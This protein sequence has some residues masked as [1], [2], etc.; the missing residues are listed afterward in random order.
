MRVAL[1]EDEAGQAELVSSW[2]ER[3]GHICTTYDSGKGF[4]RQLGRES[5]DILILDWMLPDMTGEEVLHWIHEN[6]SNPPPVMFVTCRDS[7]VEIAMILRSGGDDYMV[8][9]VR[10]LEFLARIEALSRR[11]NNV[12]NNDIIEA[13]PYRIDSSARSMTINEKPV[14]LTNTEFELAWLLFRNVGR[15]LSRGHM[16]E[17]VWGR[18]PEIDT[19]TVD[20]YLSR[21]RK[22]LSFGPK[23]G[24]HLSA[25]YQHGYRLEQRQLN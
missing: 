18:S 7:E 6:L 10:R 5:F 13:H 19:R 23:T 22:K 16:L 24:W 25:V 1:L 12:A 20:T 9:P 8:K 15:L 2:L 21:L 11:A 4:I 17:T 14:T 3:A